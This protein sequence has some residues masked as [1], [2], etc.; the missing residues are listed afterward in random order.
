MKCEAYKIS[1]SES[2]YS[3]HYPTNISQ[4]KSVRC[5]DFPDERYEDMTPVPI[6]ETPEL[7]EYKWYVP[8]MAKN[9]T[10]VLIRGERVGK[11]HLCR[12]H[13]AK[14]LGEVI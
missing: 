9:E 13:A 11:I 12:Y 6:T 8:K 5:R 1:R 10:F 3:V 2:N 14:L 7:K 4:L